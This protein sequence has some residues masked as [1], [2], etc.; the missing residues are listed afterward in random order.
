MKKLCATLFAATVIAA[1]GFQG[2]ATAAPVSATGWPTGCTNYRAPV[3]GTGG[4]TAKCSNSNGGHYKA[5]VICTPW[6]G[7]PLVYHDAAGWNSS[8]YSVA[9]CPPNTSVKSGGIITKAS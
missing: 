4:W 1:L 6:G 9:F 3:G 7:G 5:T 2:A 8:G